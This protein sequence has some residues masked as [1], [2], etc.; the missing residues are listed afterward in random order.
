MDRQR[1]E[2]RLSCQKS[3]LAAMELHYPE[4]FQG[5]K[6]NV[7]TLIKGVQERPMLET[8][9]LGQGK[10]GQDYT[11]QQAI[12]ELETKG[13]TVENDGGGYYVPDKSTEDGVLHK[14]DDPEVQRLLNVLEGAGPP[15]EGG[16]VSQTENAAHY[17]FISPETP[18]KMV[19]YTERLR[20]YQ[21]VGKLRKLLAHTLVQTIRML[22]P[23][24]ARIKT[25]PIRQRQERNGQSD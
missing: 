1:F 23:P 25:R 16:T 4:A 8:K 9:E 15:A 10:G 11:V 12:H 2:K 22:C 20:G 24:C 13:F 21:Q 6:V 5:D 7:T 19:N 3:I 18:E 17:P 14:H